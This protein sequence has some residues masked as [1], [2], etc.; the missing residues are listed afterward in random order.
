[1]R[2][3]A[4]LRIFLMAI[5][6]SKVK[7][8]TGH[9]CGHE[10]CDAKA[11]ITI[12]SP[13]ND[14]PKWFCY[15]TEGSSINIKLPPDWFDTNFLGFTLSVVAFDRNNS[16]PGY[17]DLGFGCKSYFKTNNGETIEFNCCLNNW[18][19]GVHRSGSDNAHHIITW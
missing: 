18:D 3:D 6:S 12:L 8:E 10:R 19:C 15:Q 13:G 7:Q 2:L 4:Q 14:I 9:N 5:A 17:S 16:Y 1:M 11:S